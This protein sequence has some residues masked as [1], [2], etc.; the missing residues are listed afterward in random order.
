MKYLIILC[1]FFTL[2]CFAQDQIYVP[3]PPGGISDIIAR[4]LSPNIQVIN[5]SGPLSQSAQRAAFLNKQ[6]LLIDMSIVFIDHNLNNVNFDVQK[7][8]DEY[9]WFITVP[10]AIVISTSNPSKNLSDFLIRARKMELLY[11]FSGSITQI[12]AKEFL[13]KYKLSGVGVPYRG[14][15]NAVKSVATGETIFHVGN[16]IGV[17]PLVDAGKIRIIGTSDSLN[18]RTQGYWGIALPSSME[19]STKQKWR[20]TIKDYI[21]LKN[22]K[23]SFSIKSVENVDAWMKKQNDYY[24]NIIKNDNIQ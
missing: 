2:K 12:A 4:T 9:H 21:T 23:Y 1:L 16:I 8:F 19:E 22:N 13:Q 15:V 11:A 10:N 14:G 3:H 6:P 18:L 17:Q 7:H 24:S 20:K 5:S